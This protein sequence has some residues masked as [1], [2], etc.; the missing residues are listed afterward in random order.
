MVINMKALISTAEPRETGYRIAQVEKDEN[1]FAVS[2]EL[3]WVDCP[4]DTK[5]D[6]AW[7]DPADQQIKDFPKPEVRLQPQTEG[8]QT[9]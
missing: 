5:A 3:F 7:Y 6:R 2:S 9:L 1:I 8:T 4:V